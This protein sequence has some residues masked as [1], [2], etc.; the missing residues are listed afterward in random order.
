MDVSFSKEHEAFR[1]ELLDFLGKTLPDGWDP[2]GTEDPYSPSD[3]Q[4]A[5]HMATM[6]EKRV[7]YHGLA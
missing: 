7:A 1:R 3:I 4:F 5:K 6:L 2:L